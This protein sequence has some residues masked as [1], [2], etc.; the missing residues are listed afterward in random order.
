MASRRGFLAEMQHQQRL[1][2]ARANAAARAQT[3]ARAQAVRARAQQE[4]ANAAMAR[5]DEAERK[6]YEREAK[7]AY[8]EM[9][10]AE[11]DELNEDLALEYGEIDGLLALTLDLD[12]YVD[13]EGLKV[14]AVHPPFPR[15]DLETPR[16][17][18]LPT[19]VPEAPVFIE[20]PAP[21]GLFGKKKRFEEAQQRARAEYEQAWGQWAAYRDWIPTQDAQQA[22]EHATLEEGRIKLLA[23]ERERY[24]A[25]CAVREAEVAEQNSSIDTLIAGLGYGA[26]DA[27][28]EYVG[29]VLANSLYPDSFPVEHEAEFDPATAE[30]TL[31]VTVPAPDALRTI[32]GFRYVKASDEV[33]ETQLSKTAANERYASALHQVALRS[34]HEIFEADRRGLIKAISAQIGPEAND[35]ATGRQKF[36]P[37]VAVAAPRDTFMEIDL[38]GVV[39]LATL[40]HLGAAVA[41]NPSALTAIDTAGVRRS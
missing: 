41:K 19:P 33:V 17:A 4:R 7:A 10:Q 37:L 28:Q 18:P 36:I 27:V 2:Q 29:I 12:D 39:P 5:A 23:A 24:D 21:T 13:L 16:P 31:R 15:W 26:V 9:R 1:A 34:L 11:V 40:Q 38:S 25:A 6:R 32:K 22:Q 8:V 14:R 20:P 35:P 30:L 3:Q